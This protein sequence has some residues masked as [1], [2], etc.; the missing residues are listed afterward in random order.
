[1]EIVP[2]T[3]SKANA[4]RQLKDFL[5]IDYIVAFGDGRN[6]IEMFE[7]ADESYAVENAVDE[8]IEI[9]TGIIGSNDAD[10]VAKWLKYHFKEKVNPD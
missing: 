9:A 7:I 2:K 10:G 8:L 1:M 6:D 3:V 5:G 4:I